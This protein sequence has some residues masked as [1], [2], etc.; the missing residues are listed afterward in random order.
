MGSVR[1][2]HDGEKLA[3]M[4]WLNADRENPSHEYIAENE[5]RALL[6][7]SGGLRGLVSS[8]NCPLR[9]IAV[10]RQEPD[11]IPHVIRFDGA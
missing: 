10:A 6:R 3:R 11:P 7:R 9:V 4:A 8:T 2:D 1:G 5:R